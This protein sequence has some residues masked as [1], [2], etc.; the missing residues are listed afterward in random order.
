MKCVICGYDDNGTGDSAH[1]CSTKPYLPRDCKHGQLARSCEICGL[2]AENAQLKEELAAR[3]W[4]P[5]ETAPKDMFSRL[6]RVRGYCV[7]GFVDAAGILQSQNDRYEWQKMVAN[8]THWMPLPA[9]P[10]AKL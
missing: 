4:Q 10:G 9:A 2:E 8:P 3:A 1:M 6:Y 5:I 7:Q